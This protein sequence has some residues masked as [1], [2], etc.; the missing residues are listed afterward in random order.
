[1]PSR[2]RSSA[3]THAKTRYQPSREIK[4]HIAFVPLLFLVGMVWLVY[5]R[6][7]AFPVWFDETIGKAIFFGLP[8]L[9]YISLT[10]S[11]SIQDTF[12]PHKIEP[13]LLLGIA[14][15]GIFGFAGTLATLVQRHAVV[16]AAPMFMADGFWW[17]FFLA[18][19]TGFWESL[20]FF[21]WVQTVV[22]EKFHKWSVAQQIGTTVVIFLAFH[23]PNLILR[24]PL[25]ALPAT[26]FLLAVFGIGQA[27][28]FYRTR[29][30]Y[31]LTLSQAIWGMVLL[32]HSR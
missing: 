20:F 23:L 9:L 31:A 24:F 25:S 27:L 2:K 11:R 29:N 5:R 30:L 12:A 26:V 32:I 3:A 19:M 18:L 15:G 28:F 13:G 8:V 6:L 17:E 4:R 1:M 10:R 21:C 14:V 16:Q 22:T 7:F